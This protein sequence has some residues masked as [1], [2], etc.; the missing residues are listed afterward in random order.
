MDP[1]VSHDKDESSG[2]E[3]FDPLQ[4][5]EQLMAVPLSREAPAA[6]SYNPETDPFL[7]QSPHDFPVPEEVPVSPDAL[8][9][10]G[11]W[12]HA[13]ETALERSGNQAVDKDSEVAEQAPLSFM[14]GNESQHGSRRWLG[15]HKMAWLCVLLVL[16]LPA[17]FLVLERDHVAATV[18]AL[19]PMLLWGCEL[20]SCSIT[21]PRQIEAIA[22]E[23]ST[24]TSI[25]PGVYML[26][27]SLKNAASI[28][29][30][31]PALELTLTDVH[32]QALVRRVLLAK[33]FSD[34]AQITA[35]FEFSTTV[36]ISVQMGAEN[37]KVAGYKLLVFYP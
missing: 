26:G 1:A 3:D 12:G 18:P 15:I 33:D 10:A 20:L 19:R 8:G 17:Q 2:L 24:F 21:A 9:T 30:A 25:K 5:H 28:A 37:Q 16:M 13:M 4:P 14:S 34:K 31:A 23:S 27:V 35:G 29:L 11:A 7:E 32:D 36:P 22:I 6:L